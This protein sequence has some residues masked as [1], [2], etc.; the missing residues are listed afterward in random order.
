MSRTILH[1]DM[2]NFFASVECMLDPTLKNRPIAVCGNVE[3]RHGIVLAKNELA[4]KCGVK[5]AEPLWQAREKCRDLLAV[6]PHYDEYVKMSRMARQIYGRYTELV[7][8][9]G[10]DECWLDLTAGIRFIGTGDKIA[11]ELRKTVKDEL[12]LTISVGVSFNKVFAKLGSDMKKPDAVTFIPEDSFREKIWH[13]PASELLGV[14]HTTAKKLNSWGIQTI[15]ELARRPKESLVRIFGKHGLQLWHYANGLDDAPV[16]PENA[17]PPA[18]SVGH[19]IT[20]LEDLTDDEEV[21]RVILELCQEIGHRLFSYGQKATGVSISAKDKDLST[22]Q[23][24][25]SLPFATNSP[26]LIAEKAFSLFRAGYDW[27]KSVRAVSV[28]AIQ[29]ASE[30]APCQLDIF[31]MGNAPIR[32]ER[33]DLTVEQLRARFGDRILRNACLLYNPKMP[34]EHPPVCLPPAIR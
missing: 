24:Q 27:K 31:T 15:G 33:L 22:K 32:R 28:T 11:N 17:F 8:P 34:G 30:N 9:F 13:L 3:E 21:W 10:M 26:Y 5:T 14:G 7:E 1:C 12:G 23:W 29:L 20:T 19:G 18:K 25:G 16:I 6:P 2:N 4:K